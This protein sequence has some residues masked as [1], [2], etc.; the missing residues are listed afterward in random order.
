M[1]K[2]HVV[3]L[4]KVNRKQK[5]NEGK[6]MDGTHHLSRESGIGEG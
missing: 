5:K 1:F 4:K 2:F 6:K 3:F